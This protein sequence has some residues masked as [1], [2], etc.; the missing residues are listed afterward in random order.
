MTYTDAPW[1]EL[2]ITPAHLRR[3]R[4]TTFVPMRADVDA[5]SVLKQSDAAAERLLARAVSRRFVAEMDELIA[6]ARR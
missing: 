6:E 3:H 2:P 4:V 5:R 1:P